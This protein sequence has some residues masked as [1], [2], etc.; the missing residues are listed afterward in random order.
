[1]SSRFTSAELLKPLK[2]VFG[3]SAF[4][5]LQEQIILDSLS[6]RDVFALL[7]TG[8][9]KS[10]CFQLPALVRPGLTVVVSPLI[11]LMKDQVDALRANGVAATFLN[12]TL[13][14]A[15]RRARWRGLH[16]REFKLLYV[17]PERLLAGALLDE[18]ERWGVACVAVDEAHCI[19]EWGHD[20]RPEYRQLS[21]LR[22]RLPE[23]PF[24][25]LTATAT[26]RVRDDIIRQ[27]NLRD[28]ALYVAS[29]NRP[30]LS[31]RVEPKQSAYRQ[32]LDFVR[33]RPQDSGIVYCASRAG[34]DSLASKLC[35]DGV[36]AASYHA[37]LEKEERGQTQ[38]RFLRDEV[39]VVCATIAFGMGINKPN[40]RFV[41]HSDLP[42]NIE[43]YYQETGR[44]GR[45]GLP[46]ECL[47]LFS[48]GDVAKQ[49]RFIDE[50]P[51]EKEQQVARQQLQT[52]V[53]YA[54][55]PQCRRRA[56]LDYFGESYPDPN[57]GGC[58]NCQAPR[59][60]YD[61]T[62]AAQKLMSCIFRIRQRSGTGFGLNHVV[63]VLTG[64]D[65]ERVR[66]Y[67]HQ[68]LSTFGIG[69]EHSRNEWGAIARE[70]IGQG[71]LSQST[72]QYPTL[73][74]TGAGAAALKERRP[75]RLTKPREQPRQRVANAGD[76]D[77]D[78]VLFESLR[79]LRKEL[80]DREG[81]PPYIVFGDGTLRWM[82]R[83][84]P[85]TES[86]LANIS[87]VGAMKLRNYGK[88][89]LSV[90][91]THLRSQNRKTFAEAPGVT[92]EKVVR[93]RGELLNTSVLETLRMFREGADLDAL[94]RM[95]S[96]AISTIV[97]H[98]C[99][100]IEAGE[101]L[102][103][104]KLFSAADMVQMREAFDRLPGAALTPVYDSLGGRLSYEQL[105][106]FRALWFA[107]QAGNKEATTPRDSR[108]H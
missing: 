92:G 3:Y 39:R 97:G 99:S 32:V 106:L 51:D 12:S 28:P 15:E 57:C 81:V 19:S 103:W 14:E 9:G 7:P 22:S 91:Q 87:G 72:G 41:I 13:T 49:I 20:F 90:I 93:T 108:G 6:G 52:M 29:F 107:G 82:A 46:A 77:C 43:G 76:I 65:S 56:L 47:L 88:A 30:N 38:D 64:S 10:L 59:E 74:L 23:T 33:Q 44:A 42:K 69:Q 86:E 16:A 26:E 55:C 70:L 78:E 104:S 50:K 102:D 11:A 63:A 60:S 37:G 96:L 101:R 89:V 98:L 62:L 17:A 85:T 34:A 58:D 73:E 71:L 84:Y 79:Q 53:R 40:V 48:A 94:A 35:G 4:R 31:Y 80:A 8:G 54:E 95:R 24:M 18:L 45:D 83:V 5:P 105:R 68:E 1:M 21:G 25:A 36:R 75:I 61:G 67:G 100:A 27:L 2:T 66:Q